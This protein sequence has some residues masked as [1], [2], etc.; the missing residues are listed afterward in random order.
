[1]N[2]YEQRKATIDCCGTLANSSYYDKPTKIICPKTN[3][4]IDNV[5]IAQSTEKSKIHNDTN[6]YVKTS[7]FSNDGSYLAWTC[8]YNI[9]KLMKVNEET[10]LE[11]KIHF[12]VGDIVEVEC[13]EGVKSVAFGTSKNQNCSRRI[14]FRPLKNT[15]NRFNLGDNNL[16]LAIG[17][18]SGKIKIFDMSNLSLIMNLYDHRQ[19]IND[20]K[21]TQDGSLQLMSASNDETIKLWNLYEDGN[22]YHTFKGHIGKVN[23]C[24]W[25]PTAK[26]VCSAGMNRQAYV[27]DTATMKL[28][29]TLKGHLHTVSSCLFSPDGALVVTA[30]YDTKICLWNP[31]SGEMIKQFNHMLPP[32]RLI[33]AG[34]DNGAYIRDISFSREGSH[35]LS[36][37]DD[38]KIRMWSLSSRSPYPIVAGEMKDIGVSCAYSSLTRTVVVGTR[39]GHLDLYKTPVNAPKL[40]DLCRKV[41]NRHISQ[42]VSELHLPKEL[43][44]FLSY[45][46]IRDNSVGSTPKRSD[47]VQP[48]GRNGSSFLM[49]DTV[50]LCN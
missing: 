19:V 50:A 1:M 37:C 14:H 27:W 17:L 11:N 38:K 10:Q 32:P 8:G 43:K 47:L 40:T 48:M 29:H 12:N 28:K 21:F 49:K 45:D 31:F 46:E 42:P 34:G 33:Y 30:S 24:D 35:L 16:F 23:M 3:V 18:V 25:S 4:L 36:V 15:N 41:V 26:L 44:K 39:T 7:V 22:M 5:K 6:L 20:I 13:A 9:I 2:I